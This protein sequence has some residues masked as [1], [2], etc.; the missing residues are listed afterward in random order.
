MGLGIQ[1]TALPISII[2]LIT[3]KTWADC[4]QA[5]R[6][7]PYEL[8]VLNEVWQKFGKELVP[9]S[10]PVCSAET[11][12]SFSPIDQFRLNTVRGNANLTASGVDLRGAYCW[13]Q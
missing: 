9:R 7:V 5:S 10:G 3:N 2:R 4:T 13:R 6:Y 8:Y 12:H 1:W 11:R